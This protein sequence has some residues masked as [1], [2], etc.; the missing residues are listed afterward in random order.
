[1]TRTADAVVIGAGVIGA[2]IALELARAGRRVVVVDKAG[3]IGHGSTSAS[4]AIVRFHYSTFTGVAL[5]WEARHCWEDWRGHLGHRRPRRAGDVRAHRHARARAGPGAS[6]AITALFDAV[7]VPWE[8]WSRR[9]DPRRVPGLDAGRV[10]AAE[11]GRP[12]D[13]FFAAAQGELGGT[14]DAGCGVRRRPTAGR[15]QP[16]RGRA[17][18]RREVP[19]APRGHR[20]RA[21]GPRRWRVDTGTDGD[22]VD[23]DVVVNAAGPWSG[24]RQR[25]GRRRR[26]LHGH[27]AAVA[28]GGA[29]ARAR[30]DE[31]RHCSWRSPTPTSASTCA[32]RRRQAPGRR[33]GA[34]VRPAGV[35]RR[36]E[37]PAT[38]VTAAT[39]RRRP[40]GPPAGCPP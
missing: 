13:E 34:R 7:G 25:A 35:A 31:R 28:A 17:Q 26:G 19:A 16:G 21:A 20:R 9:R 6:A 23:C 38:H 11:A 37:T 39:S 27:V 2:A 30:P 10:R 22:P 18:P 12:P 5:A 8:R 15:A 40:C 3:G 1:M 29:P 32:R 33:D 14:L 24:A 36:P 4:S